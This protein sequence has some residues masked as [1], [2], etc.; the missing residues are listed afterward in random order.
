[1]AN[2]KELA[3]KMEKVFDFPDKEAEK[4]EILAYFKEQEKAVN[5]QINSIIK[6]SV[7][8][9]V[10]NGLQTRTTID[11]ATPQQTVHTNTRTAHTDTRTAHTDIFRQ[12]RLIL[13]DS[14]TITDLLLCIIAFFLFVL[15]IIHN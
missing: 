2:N 5:R 13:R 1:M 10:V 11:S 8:A 7:A 15:I 9:P 3:L 4:Y 14:F 6:E 12:S